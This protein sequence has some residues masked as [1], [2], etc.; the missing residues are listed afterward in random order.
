[1]IERHIE[2]KG[3]V[4]TCADGCRVPWWLGSFR[5]RPE[6]RRFDYVPIGFNVVARV[7]WL[8][9][10]W[11]RMP[12]RENHVEQRLREVRD[13]DATFTEECKRYERH[14]DS[15]REHEANLERT[16]AERVGKITGLTGADVS[17]LL[18]IARAAKELPE[19]VVQELEATHPWTTRRLSRLVEAVKVYEQR[20]SSPSASRPMPRPEGQTT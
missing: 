20:T 11:I 17:A 7:L 8:I 12:L 3:L 10:L 6:A 15:L 14:F 1:M 19:S 2:R 13:L 5:F 18:E 4:W 9:Y 16:H